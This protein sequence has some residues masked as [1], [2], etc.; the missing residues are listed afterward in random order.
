MLYLKLSPSKVESIWDRFS[1]ENMT[2]DEY[3]KAIDD[4]TFVCPD[5]PKVRDCDNG[6]VACDSYNQYK[7]DIKLIKD[8][9]VKHYR[10]S[11]AWTRICPDGYC[12]KIN[13]K[14]IDFYKTFITELK[15]NGIEPFVTLY[16]WDLPQVLQDERGG[17]ADEKADEPG[18]GINMAFK[19]YAEV[20][21][22]NF[23][24]QVKQWITFNEAEVVTDL[25]YGYG[26]FAPGIAD[27]KQ[28]WRARHNTVRSHSEA[29]AS[30]RA[31]GQ[32][33]IIGITINTDHYIPASNSAND[34]KAAD[35]QVILNSHSKIESFLLVRTSS[36]FLGRA[37]LWK[38]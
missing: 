31:K 6:D 28:K 23:G 15:A 20:C 4:G 34:V 38:W 37:N 9:G 1:H 17:W 14:G 30:Y 21:F 24:D 18:V 11:L 8:L 35:L 19:K 27:E 25:G 32:G 12:Q 22:D 13:Q 26:V 10:F 5:N 29:V 16:H 3:R 2:P 7:R 36:W 33:G